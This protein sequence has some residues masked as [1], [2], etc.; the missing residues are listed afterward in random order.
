MKIIFLGT[1]G[2]CGV[3]EWNCNCKVCKSRDPKD[4]RLRSC[5]YVEQA[6]KKIVVDFGPDF[7]TQLLKH[8][9]KNLTNALLTHA[10]GDHMNGYMELARQRD[11]VLEAPKDVLVEFSRRLGSSKDWLQT[12]NPSMVVQ[13]L[14]KLKYDNLEI[15]PIPLEHKK[16][17]SQV[18]TPCY[19]YLFKKGNISF[20]Y[21]SDFNNIIDDS[22][23]YNLDLIISDGNGLNSKNKGHVGIQGSIRLYKELLPKKMLITHITHSRSHKALSTYVKQFG[24]IGIAYDG[25]TVQL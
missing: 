25:L 1:G 2:V 15:T 19:G 10:H 9:I 20:A 24:S 4:N 8:H 7:R 3:P 18:R 21:L 22:L 14:T 23:L 11:L 16:D 13:P 17:Y 6:A 5:I 12:R